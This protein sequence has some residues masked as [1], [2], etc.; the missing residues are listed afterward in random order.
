VTLSGYQGVSMTVED[1]RKKVRLA[2]VL[3][4]YG[5]IN[6]LNSLQ[7]DKSRLR[8]IIKLRLCKEGGDAGGS[9]PQG[10][11]SV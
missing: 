9:D 10:R 7:L 3:T 8:D 4:G 2:E 11:V 1:S 6:Q 5:I